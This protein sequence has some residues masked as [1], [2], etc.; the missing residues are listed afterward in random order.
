MHDT[1]WQETVVAGATVI[2]TLFAIGGLVWSLAVSYAR[3]KANGVALENVGVD[4][5][6][7]NGKVTNIDKSFV[8]LNGTL[9]A[10]LK[11]CDVH[12]LELAEKCS[13][14]NRRIRDSE[15]SIRTL[16]AER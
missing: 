13:E 9:E 1:T 2:G 4:V 3:G 16:R 8:T 11:D 5:A 10:H 7:I 6:K 14:H 15:E 12:R